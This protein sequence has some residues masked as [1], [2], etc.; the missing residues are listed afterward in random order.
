MKQFY[1]YILASKKEGVL[2]IGVTNDLERR[3]LEHKTK[4]N[5]GFTSKYN[6][7]KLMY[8]EIFSSIEAAILREKQM[9]KWKREWKVNRIVENNP[10]WE[11]LSKEW[12][13]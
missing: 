4:I 2:Y 9:K 13:N 1:V 10:S 11:D 7:D 6:I 3:V 8:F 5:K 12:F